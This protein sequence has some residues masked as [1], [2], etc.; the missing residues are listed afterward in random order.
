MRATPMRQPR[1]TRKATPTPQGGRLGPQDHARQEHADQNRRATAGFEAR[2]ATFGEEGPKERRG[3]PSKAPPSRQ[4]T[5]RVQLDPSQR[6]TLKACRQR[7]QRR[8]TPPCGQNHSPAR[9]GS[10]QIRVGAAMRGMRPNARRPA[11]SALRAASRP[12]AARSVTNLRFRYVA[13]IIASCTDMAMRSHGGPASTSI[14][15]QS[16]SRFGAARVGTGPRHPT[17]KVSQGAQVERLAL[18]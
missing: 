16:R 8:S 4:R 12:L 15:C 9:Q 14:P 1:A 13:S 2:L 17:P 7:I 6:R 18:S 3:K 10:P 5:I 11:S